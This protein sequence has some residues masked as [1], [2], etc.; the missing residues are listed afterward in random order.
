M[1]RRWLVLFVFVIVLLAAAGGGAYVL[2][3]QNADASAAVPK[4]HKPQY[5]V[6][7][8]V[9]HARA[10][11]QH[12]FG[13]PRVTYPTLT[14]D[15]SGRYVLRL[16]QLL[17]HHGYL[18]VSFD[19]KGRQPMYAL[20]PRN[21]TFDWTFDAPAS[22][23]AQWQPH[24]F[25]VVT[26]GAVMA[27]EADNNMTPDGV[28]GPKVWAALLSP[29]PRPAPRPYTYVYVSETL[30]ESI[31]IYQKGAVAFHTAANTG[32]AD[33][34]TALGTY[35]VYL[36]YTSATMEGTNPDGSHYN[37]PGVPWISYFN[38]GDAVHGFIR[39]SYGSPQS[40]GCVELSYSDAAQAYQLMSYGTLV[41]VAA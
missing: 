5:A 35:P 15:A 20:A 2:R 19:A 32:I 4:R 23:K 28:A 25:G 33:A 30:P 9:K 27:F 38:G 31:T 37:D 40:L 39:P 21:G 18:P 7:H 29:K 16:Q 13:S 3:S 14:T 26:R 17:A 41:T 22:L 34:P 36:R 6:A 8:H 10:K 1:K 24:E 12:P 11:P